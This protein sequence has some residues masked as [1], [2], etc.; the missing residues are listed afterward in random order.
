[1]EAGQ[2]LF[3]NS[4]ML[5]AG[6]MWTALDCHYLSVT[7]HPRLLYGYKSSLMASK[8]IDPIVNQPGLSSIHLVPEVDWMAEIL[9]EIRKI[10]EL[11]EAEGS[12]LAELTQIISLLTIW[13]SLYEH[14]RKEEIPDTKNRDTERIR[15]LM[16][17]IRSHYG[18][19]I[20]LEQLADQVHLCKS[21]TCRMFRRYMNETI[22]DY[23]MKFR[24]E[25][26]LELLKNEE[27]NISQISELVGF[28]TPGYFT[29]NFRE[30][31]GQTP[32]KYRRQ[33]LS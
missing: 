4:N 7:F 11:F 15:T 23:L 9:R 14:A 20:T 29:K 25:R 27:L 28:S 21:E 16:A 24:I 26:S 33:L 3:C 12:Q 19:A 5:H 2:G 1:M 30:Q 13:Q 32:M 18:E 10:M 6:G 8:Y 31:M 22:F 17:Y